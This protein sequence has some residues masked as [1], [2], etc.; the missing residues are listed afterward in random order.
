MPAYSVED[1]GSF[2][3]VT[4]EVKPGV[5]VLKL[6]D[7]ETRFF[8]ALWEIP[9]G[10]SYNAYVVDYGEG[11]ILVDGWK[12]GYGPLLVDKLRQ[13]GVLDKLSHVVVN[14]MEPD[15]SGSLPEVLEA[16]KGVR[17]LG[18]PL[19]KKL[20]KDFYGLE[21]DFKPVADGE[22]LPV[23]P[24]T[25]KFSHVPWLHWPETIV[26]QVEELGVLFTCDVFGSFGSHRAVA[27]RELGE[28]QRREY[29]ALA[30]KYF[31]DVVA[32]YRDF[33]VKASGKLKEAIS[34]SEL[35]AP[36]HGLVLDRAE[37]SGLL[38][39]YLDWSTSRG[40]KVVLL[41]ASMYGHSER[42]VV[43]LSRRLKE[44]GVEVSSHGFTDKHRH[45]VS[46]IV[47]DALGAGLIVVVSTVYE[48][49]TF[50]LVKYTLELVAHKTGCGK[51]LF[52]DVHGWGG[53]GAEAKKLLESLGCSD[54]AVLEL[55]PFEASTSAERVVQQALDLLARRPGRQEGS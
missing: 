45:H 30:R 41:Y 42:L 10:V 18:H 36:G 6:V 7:G 53:K 3:V 4:G 2:Q 52:V 22:K 25:L 47:N 55:K 34:T 43:E 49:S 13:L 44:E 26:T 32:H 24:L 48:N 35:V 23:G 54:I 5:R 33:V 12:T 46:E 39:L 28:E 8:E 20:I 9:E 29:Y 19:T 27:L 31:A 50:P 16:R 11:A 21:P 37:A 15:H 51:V 40:G 17:V 1:H 38:D 14:H